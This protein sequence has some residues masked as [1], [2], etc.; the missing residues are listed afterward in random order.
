MSD[1]SLKEF[2][3]SKTL[4]VVA[5]RL[6]KPISDDNSTMNDF[7]AQSRTRIRFQH[8]RDHARLCLF[9]IRSMLTIYDKS[10]INE[11]TSVHMG[12]R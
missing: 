11:R 6:S 5:I 8:L 7:E 3:N 10:T 9:N 2:D 12:D 1:V 4:L